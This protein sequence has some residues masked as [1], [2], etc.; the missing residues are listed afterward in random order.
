MTYRVNRYGLDGVFLKTY[1]DVEG[2]LEDLFPSESYKKMARQIQDCLDNKTRYACGCQW[3]Y[4]DD[5]YDM[6]VFSDPHGCLN[7]TLEGLKQV[8]YDETNPYHKLIC[9]GD[10]TD[11]GEQ[12]LALYQ[13]LYELET[14]GRAIVLAG[15]HTKFLI[16]Y[17]D[18]TVISPFNYINNGVDETLAD[19]L[20]RTRP[21]ESW[22]M[23]DENINIPTNGDF[24]RWITQARREINEEY[25]ELLP[26]LKSLPRYVETEHFIGVHG[27][28]DVA[29][30][31][32]HYPRC[33]RYTLYDWDALDFDD[34]SFFKANIINTNKTIIIGHFGTYH[35]REKYPNLTKEDKGDMYDIL[36]RDDGRIIALDA[37][38]NLSGKINVLVLKDE[39]LYEPR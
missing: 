39:V 32:W 17:L 3:K 9:L 4:D 18:G 28:I 30:D 37:T 22:C 8:G 34:G 31:D 14:T 23:I 6:F 29:V 26:W 11:R 12:T 2:A 16:E 15:N 20:H 13:Y 25:P 21:F 35:L 7:A 38:T 27:A 5:K 33:N 24:A 36:I 10:F 19:F 1:D